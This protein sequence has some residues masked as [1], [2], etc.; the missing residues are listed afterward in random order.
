MGALF[1]L[2]GVLRDGLLED[3]LGRLEAEENAVDIG[4]KPRRC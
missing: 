2:L 1:E 3:V 4:G